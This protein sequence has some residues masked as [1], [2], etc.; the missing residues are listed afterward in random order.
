M[1]EREPRAGDEEAAPSPAGA[2]VEAR[3]IAARGEVTADDVVDVLRAV[4]EA[5]G[6]A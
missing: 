1:N 6:R 3:E 5:R 2:A 4:R